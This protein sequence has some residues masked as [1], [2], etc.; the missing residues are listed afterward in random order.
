MHFL[1]VSLLKDWAR[2]RRDPFQILTALGIPLVLVL[3][4]VDVVLVITATVK[5]SNG[6]LYRYPYCLRLIK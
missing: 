5:A 4:V 1:A 6:E 2:V 3:A